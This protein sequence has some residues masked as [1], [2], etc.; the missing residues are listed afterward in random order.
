LGFRI[1][2]AT[3]RARAIGQERY[4]TLL[5]DSDGSGFTDRDLFDWTGNHFDPDALAL[6]LGSAFAAGLA[7]RS[8]TYLDPP[9]ILAGYD[10]LKRLVAVG[11]VRVQRQPV[12]IDLLQA[13]LHATDAAA[14]AAGPARGRGGSDGQQAGSCSGA[15]AQ[16]AP[17]AP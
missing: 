11:E 14:T 6:R 2:S 9:A 7:Q 17:A 16:P 1:P 13:F 4:L 5:R 3:E 10:Q 15:P 8:H 12:P